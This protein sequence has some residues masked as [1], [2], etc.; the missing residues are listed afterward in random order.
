[1]TELHEAEYKREIQSL[2]DRLKSAYKDLKMNNEQ[3][4]MT[5]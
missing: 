1:M 3:H 2:E 5:M 4:A